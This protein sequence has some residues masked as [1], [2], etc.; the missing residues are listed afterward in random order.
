MFL[1]CDALPLSLRPGAWHSGSF[2]DDGTVW[3]ECGSM[4][5]VDLV[6]RKLFR[7]EP[8]TFTLLLQTRHYKTDSNGNLPLLLGLQGTMVA[9]NCFHPLAADMCRF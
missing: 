3:L 4:C 7:T 1:F 9:K 5:A 8:V 2:M 6:T